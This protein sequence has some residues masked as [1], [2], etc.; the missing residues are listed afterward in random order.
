MGVNAHLALMG[1]GI[2]GDF[3]RRIHTRVKYAEIEKEFFPVLVQANLASRSLCHAVKLGERR[4]AAK[5][6]PALGAD[7][8]AA[9]A[10]DGEPPQCPR[11]SLPA[12]PHPRRLGRKTVPRPRGARTA[13]IGPR[14]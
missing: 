5:D 12:G 13:A 3:A 1:Q 11:T 8:A 2:L 9:A 14:A 6:G 4:A 10:E 7:V